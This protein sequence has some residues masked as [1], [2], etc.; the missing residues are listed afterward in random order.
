MKLADFL[1][2][3][4]KESFW[5]E[6]RIICFRSEEFS[7]LFFRLLF[8]SLKEKGIVKI[9]PLR[10]E[11]KLKLW[12]TL[13]QSFLGET[14]FYW[15]GD[16]AKNFSSKRKKKNSEPDV[17]E[18]LS[19][20]RGPHSIAFF[21]SNEHK[22]SASALKRMC[23]V[24]L[25]LFL[26]SLL[27]RKLFSFVS[28]EFCEK[29]LSSQKNKIVQDL[30]KTG[31]IDVDTCCML[32]YY[33]SVTSA[34]FIGEQEE[35]LAT[36][37]DPQLSLGTLSQK[38]FTKQKKQFFL[39]WSKCFP[40]YPIPFWTVYWSEQ[41]WRAYNVL[42][43]LKQNNLYAARRFSFRLPPSFIKNDWR[44]CSQK[45]LAAAYQVIYDIDF[46]F[47]TGSLSS[48]S[49]VS[50]DLFFSSYFLGTLL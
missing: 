33:L 31:R 40:L 15:L 50:L 29:Q 5:S 13:Q 25:P 30:S 38:F 10:V 18:V 36:V 22:I 42:T 24:D 41:V 43:F 12:Q 39:L 7:F 23:M 11:E 4:K 14:S 1:V 26:D 17:V 49:G 45:E 20:Y 9:T 46:G 2:E 28:K 19:H 48:A 27:V 8:A 44:R 37:I 47:K 32:A 21:V 34:K 3:A 6:N 35:K 16:I